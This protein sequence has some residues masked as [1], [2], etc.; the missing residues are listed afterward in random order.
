ML[1]VDSALA[2]IGPLLQIANHEGTLRC[3]LAIL[4]CFHI[5]VPLLPSGNPDKMTGSPGM[6]IFGTSHR[7][8]L[9]LTLGWRALRSKMA[10]AW[11]LLCAQSSAH[12]VVDLVVPRSGLPSLDPPHDRTAFWVPP[13]IASELRSFPSKKLFFRRIL[14]PS[15]RGALRVLLSTEEAPMSGGPTSGGQGQLDPRPQEASQRSSRHTPVGP[16]E[17]RCAAGS[18]GFTLIGDLGFTVPE[19]A[20][21]ILKSDCS[22]LVRCCAMVCCARRRVS[23]AMR[24]VP[25]TSSIRR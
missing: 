10:Q 11:R 22:P 15:P 3:S 24:E 20:G 17:H 5:A 4:A 21:A 19:R 14:A 1:A 18:V 13:W 12:H 16:P 7:R 23:C 8:A 6:P 2:A 9:E 25:W